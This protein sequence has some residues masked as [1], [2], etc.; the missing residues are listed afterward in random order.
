MLVS[1]YSALPVGCMIKRL[2]VV[3]PVAVLYWVHM[4]IDVQRYSKISLSFYCWRVASE[5]VPCLVCCRAVTRPT[6]PR[7]CRNP[8]LISLCCAVL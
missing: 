3:E 2:L 1:P 7:L 5:T 6:K 4:K 8:I